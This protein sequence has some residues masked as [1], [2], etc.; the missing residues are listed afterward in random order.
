MSAF[1]GDSSTLSTVNTTLVDDCDKENARSFTTTLSNNHSSTKANAKAGAKVTV[2]SGKK[3]PTQVLSPVTLKRP[4]TTTMPVSSPF[5]P[6]E[7]KEKSS[8]RLKKSKAPRRA[9]NISG[10][11]D[12]SIDLTPPSSDNEEELEHFGIRAS[13]ILAQKEPEDHSPMMMHEY[14]SEEDEHDDHHIEPP[15]FSDL[16][17]DEEDEREKNPTLKRKQTPPSTVAKKSNNRRSFSSFIATTPRQKLN[18]SN[19]NTPNTYKSKNKNNSSA[20]YLDTPKGDVSFHYSG[21]HDTDLDESFYP[22]DQDPE[23]EEEEQELMNMST[24]TDV[25][26]ESLNESALNDIIHQDDDEESEEEDDGKHVRRSKRRRFKPLAWYKGEHMVYE[27]RQSGVGLVIPT[28]AG[29][30]R[31]GTKTPEPKSHHHHPLNHRKSSKQVKTCAII[32]PFDTRRLKDTHDHVYPQHDRVYVWDERSQNGKD[33]MLISRSQDRESQKFQELES[34]IPGVPPAL[35]CQNFHIKGHDSFP[36]WISGALELPPLSQKEPEAVG[37]CTQVFY[38]AQGQPKALEVAIAS[39]T[40]NHFDP[41]SA[42][43]Y[44]LSPGDEFYIPPNNAYMFHN[45][46]EDVVAKVRFTII[47]SNIM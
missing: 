42:Q 1:W 29:I 47:K 7:E 15:S 41:K 38:V 31:A 22:E 35:A 8:S 32:P 26:N 2:M 44:L 19:F 24:A 12:I 34:G 4:T 25:P 23:E 18:A 14:E 17:E 10:L 37:I 27:R 45:H 28:V 13:P 39:P 46:S 16:S 36:S 11:T 40:E 3:S 5:L 20:K 30:E 6:L 33:L 9:H 43:R 21:N